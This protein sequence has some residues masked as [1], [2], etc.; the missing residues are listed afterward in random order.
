MVKR[1]LMEV[2]KSLLPLYV[3]IRCPG[4][5]STFH[6]LIV[7]A[8]QPSGVMVEERKLFSKRKAS[9]RRFGHTKELASLRISFRLGPRTGGQ[10]DA[11]P[12]ATSNKCEKETR[13]RRI[14]GEPHS[15][16]VPD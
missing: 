16:L 15:P 9:P 11:L 7:H 14:D 2:S 5:F 10:D 13:P 4:I 6:P 1:C 8:I 12:P 3:E